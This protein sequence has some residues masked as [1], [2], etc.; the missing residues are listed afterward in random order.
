MNLGL[1]S[2]SDWLVG[3][4]CRKGPRDP[5]RRLWLRPRQRPRQRL[6]LRR[7][8]LRPRRPASAGRGTSAAPPPTTTVVASCRTVERARTVPSRSL[9]S[10]WRTTGA[11]TSTTTGPRTPARMPR[12]EE[13]RVAKRNRTLGVNVCR[14]CIFATPP[15]LPSTNF[16]V[17]GERN[18]GLPQC[19]LW[20]L[21]LVFFL[22]LTCVVVYPCFGRHILWL[23]VSLVT[24]LCF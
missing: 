22:G 10:P 24:Y 13:G 18:G 8:V 5:R 4:T 14:H 2:L 3:W 17:V 16:D 19:K 15:G 1:G 21:V 12:W 7:V 11:T 6:R 20:P 23:P 9:T